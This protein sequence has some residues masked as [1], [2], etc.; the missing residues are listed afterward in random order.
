MNMKTKSPVAARD[1]STVPLRRLMVLLAVLASVP[2]APAAVFVKTNNVD[3]LNLG[4]SWTNSAAPGAA[5]IAQ[6]DGTVTDPNNTTNTL[7]ASTTWGGIKI[8]NP[9]AAIT[10]ITNAGGNTLTLGAGGIDMSAA[11]AS[12]TMSNNVALLGSTVQP[13]RVAAGQTLALDGTFTRQAGAEL[14]LD[15]SAGGVINIEGGTA[16]AALNYTLINGTDVAALDA[17]KNVST[18]STVIGYSGNVVGGAPSTA[19]M[20]VVNGNTG[21]LPDVAIGSTSYTPSVVRFNTPQP[22]RNYW[23][24]AVAGRLNYVGGQSTYLVTTNVGAQDVHLTGT[25]HTLRWNSGTE[26]ILDQEN[27]AGT[28]YVDGPTS[29]RIATLNNILTKYGAGRAVFNSNIAN[30]GPIRI[31]EGELMINGTI[32]AT[33]VLTVNSGATL[34]GSTTINNPITSFGGTIHAGGVNG[35]GSLTLANLTLN[36]GSGLS[37]YSAA[38]P[39]TNTTPLLNLTGGLTIGGAINVSIQASG[40]AVGQ[41]PLLHWTNAISADTFTNFSL[42]ALPLRT[43]GYLS[44]NVANNSID[45]V[46]TNVTEPVSWAVGNGNWDVN[47]TANWVDAVNAVTTYQQV[48]PFGD[49]VLF[50]DT[51]SGTSPITV[52]LNTNVTPAMVTVNNTAKDYI[53]SGGGSIA[54]GGVLTKTGAG[55]LFLQTTNL[56]SGGIN[57]NGG[58][59]NFSTLPNLGAG[60]ISFGGG[61]LQYVS[62]NV[63]DIS[64][65]P[66]TFNAGGGTINDGGGTLV[67]ANPVGNSGAG[68]LTKAGAG[69]LTLNG[70]N[71]YAGNTVVSAGTLALG[72]NTF[73]SNS[74]AIIVQ[75][76][77]VLDTAT[78]GAGL[79]LSGNPAQTL[80]GVGTVSGP[81]TAPA[82]ATISPAA[83]GVYGTLTLANDLT[84]SGGTLALDVSTTNRD[85]LFVTGNLSLIGG[86]L[87]L[88]VGNVLT[89]GVYKLIHYGVLATGAGSSGNLTLTGFAQPGQSGTL[90]DATPGEIDLIVG[91][92]ASDVIAWSGT[93]TT[94]DLAATTDWLLGGATPWAFTNGDLVTF[95]ESGLT[96]PN[97]SLMSALLPGSVTVSNTTSAYI[98]ADGTGTG[99]GK[100]SGPTSVV[101]D[102]ANVLILQTAN[103]NTGSTTIKNGTVQVGNGGIG[104]IGAGNI[105]NNGALVFNQGDGN[106]HTVAGQVAGTGTL[107][108]QGANTTV[109]LAKGGTYSGPTTI[110]SGAL[111]LGNGGAASLPTGNITNNGALILNSTGTIALANNITGSG[112][113]VQAGTSVATITGNLTYQ[114]NTYISNGVVKLTANNQIPDA[115]SVSGSTGWLILDGG[116]TAGAFDLNGFNE[117]INALS[118]V[119]GTLNG[120]ITNSSTSTA[121]TNI[122]TVLNAVSTTYSGQIAAHAPGAGAR[123]GL[124]VT[125]PG[126][127]TLN[128]ATNNTFSG[129][130]VVSN[131]SLAFGNVANGSLYAPG[132][133]PITLL[134]TNANLYLAGSGGSTGPTY[135]PLTNTITLPAGQT[136]SIYGP[137]RGSVGSMLL[138]A[139]TLYYNS[140]YVRDSISGDWSAFTG[141]IILSGNATGGN[142]GLNI[143]N[144]FPNA[145]VTI[146]TNVALYAT[147]GGTPTVPIGALAGGDGS[148]QIE[149]TSSGGGGGAATIFAIGGLNA[150]TAYGG[151]MVDNVGLLKVGTGTFTLNGGASLV[152]NITTPDSV[153]FYT[154]VTAASNLVIYTGSTTVSNGTLAL[155]LPVLLTNSPSVTLASAAAV[156][157]ASAMG[158][159]SNELASDGITVTNAMNVTNSLFEVVSG[160]SFNGIGTLIGNLQ[161]DPG[162]ILNPGNVAGN[163]ATGTGTGVLTVTGSATL[164]GTINMRLNN[165]NAVNSDKLAATSY[166]ISGAALVVTNVGP[167]SFTG[168]TVFHL[169]SSAVNTAGFATI[170]LPPST[171]SLQVNN[172]LA[173]D[174]T[175]VIVSLVNTTPTNITSVVNGGNLELSWP[176][177]HTGWRLQ[178]QT[179]SLSVGL[180]TNWVDVTGSTTVNSVTNPINPGNGSVFYRMVYP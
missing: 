91:D 6:W 4:S 111:Q 70:T 49:A 180:Y 122:L 135:A 88:Q 20:D 158:Y 2:L 51:A 118:G 62:G 34:S 125:G 58:V 176:A 154:N 53:I 133:G 8:L 47:G 116:G 78:S 104:D 157:D 36:A 31:V 151:R 144:G 124:L 46:V 64:V 32:Q 120:V 153:N 18:V 173:V 52:T 55:A 81:V 126:T 29:Q 92:S 100:I 82:G 117:T 166:A 60:S 138:G 167:A 143:I 127:L 136:A 73:I 156:L 5:D 115:N 42:V 16:S 90:S 7:G 132:T 114:G 86:T 141:Q 168:S 139:G 23:L 107:T 128:P 56:F 155:V 24:Y 48:G 140:T 103:N 172:N 93:G 66:V 162:S 28:F 98:F 142:I 38:L 177:D 27:T 170:T 178:V 25:A 175:L 94:W 72:L 40:A 50:G 147:V 148:T 87:Q 69:S 119:A 77:A 84:V 13:W 164:N 65:R 19:F 79:A 22:N 109:V 105:T 95:N 11:T 130:I 44:N 39:A 112:A 134:G 129:G 169:F 54:G 74:A 41:Y 30:N 83:N 146:N 68:G 1:Y 106:V 99:G 21:T 33:S 57:L 89:N 26:L 43:S 3:A 97:V 71:R 179:N 15:T 137:S 10:I 102:G 171:S 161:A 101:K 165:T 152:T 96:S 76:G 17:L 59:V 85:L 61:A 37:F 12:L 75:S 110:S 174:G 145:F 67:F 160:Q 108:Q 113:L 63:E 150:S 159:V 9:V 131:S 121:T 163:P 149:S 123:I 45:L 35:F 80:A 14:R